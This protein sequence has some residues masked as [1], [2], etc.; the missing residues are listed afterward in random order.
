[1]N[2][3][4]VQ[5]SINQKDKGKARTS[6]VNRV[7][8][9]PENHAP[10]GYSINN[11]EPDLSERDEP[12]AEKVSHI[13]SSGHDNIMVG[14][15]SQTRFRVCLKCRRGIGGKTYRAFFATGTDKAA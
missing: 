11:S 8:T 1:M 3:D 14:Q 7:N 5:I 6:F 9:N 13:Y 12:F 10:Y 15:H 4:A 2:E